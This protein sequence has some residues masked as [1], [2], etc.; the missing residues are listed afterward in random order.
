MT[1][2]DSNILIDIFGHDPSWNAWSKAA[3]ET[4]A[5]R[6]EVAINPIIYAE[7]S[8]G[9]ARGADLD[10]ALDEAGLRR[11]PLPYDAG[12]A[13]GKAFLE[14]RRRGGARQSP[15]PDFYIGAHA[16]LGGMELLTRDAQRYASYF[17]RLTMI[18]P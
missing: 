14:Y 4:A 18:M 3:L 6:G 15:L 13:A 5:N 1:L 2:V 7:T 11:L 16:M 10:E 8:I 17:P 9:F 12:F